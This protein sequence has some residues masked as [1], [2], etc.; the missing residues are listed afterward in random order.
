MLRDG[1]APLGCD[2]QGVTL[3]GEAGSDE[4]GGNKGYNR[5]EDSARR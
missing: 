2:A 4:R 3:L 5:Q 1:R